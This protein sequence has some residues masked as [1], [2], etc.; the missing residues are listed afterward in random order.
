MEIH[1]PRHNVVTMSIL[2]T[3]CES[4]GGQGLR[5]FLPGS[6]MS[7]ATPK[8]DIIGKV[9]SFKFLEVSDL[10]FSATWVL[11]PPC[12][13]KIVSGTHVY[14]GSIGFATNGILIARVD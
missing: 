11:S 3:M 13:S 2:P 5:G 7:G 8:E 14:I 1:S 4:Y 9:L 12:K 6:H 10:L